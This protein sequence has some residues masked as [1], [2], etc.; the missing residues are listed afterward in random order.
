MHCKSSLV[1]DYSCPTCRKSYP[2]LDGSLPILV[3]DPAWYLTDHITGTQTI[4][5]RAERALAMVAELLA[6]GHRREAALR[7]MREG[8]SVNV[9][10]VRRWH[11]AL[12]ACSP[13]TTQFA[14][15]LRRNGD[16]V[17]ANIGALRY[18]INDWGHGAENEEVIAQ[19]VEILRRQLAGRDLSSVAVLGGGA[20]RLAWELSR[21]CDAVHIFDV[22]AALALTYSWLRAEP[23]VVHQP[24]E[25][26]ARTIEDL[27]PAVRLTS[28]VP[29]R[30]RAA[31]PERVDYVI[32]D[33][34]RMPV[35]DASITA[36]V[37]VYLTDVVA[38][39]PAL[40]A[41][42]AR[43]LVP[44]GAFVNFGTLGYSDF[45]PG[46]MWTASELRDVLAEHGFRIEHEDWVPH[47]LWPS[48]ALVQLQAT[49]WSFVAVKV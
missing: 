40:L 32:G 30:D 33:V 22:S 44:G 24:I 45:K 38:S 12:T 26:N 46:E 23:I 29:E 6:T 7:R 19:L 9:E 15:N 39:I 34:L 13:A 27:Y 36:A 31:R 17:T 41:E 10:L 1:D 4:L 18:I 21:D 43:V 20:G 16:G 3:T 25:M 37:A 49:A 14:S 48:S 8:M 28:E 2:L 47:R 42:L 11:A 35:A 5:T